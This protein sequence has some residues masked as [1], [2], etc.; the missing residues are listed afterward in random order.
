MEALTGDILDYLKRHNTMVLTTAAEN[1]P[2][3][4]PLFFA[5]SGFTLYFLSDPA[6]RHSGNLVDN[7]LVSVVVTEDYQQWRDIKGIQLEG[8]AEKVTGGLEKAK[9]MAVY[10]K[11]FPFVTDFLQSKDFRETAAKVQ[12]Y[13]ITPTTIWFLDNAQGFSH[14]KRLSL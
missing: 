4:A 5:S 14:R 6:T 1:L 12:L 10:L 2:H 7:P 11:K 8:K 3:A 9:G 13:K